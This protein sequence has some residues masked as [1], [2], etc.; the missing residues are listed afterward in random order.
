MEL[1]EEPLV[2]EIVVLDK[3]ISE[4]GELEVLFP[5]E[6][7]GLYRIS[8][9]SVTTIERIGKKSVEIGKVVR[10][11]LSPPG[12]EEVKGQFLAMF[13]E[14]M[15]VVL[16][17]SKVESGISLA[18]KPEEDEIPDA[19]VWC[20]GSSPAL[21]Y[22]GR[23]VLC[24]PNNA[25]GEF[26]IEPP[27]SFFCQSE[28]DGIRILGN[29]VS[30]FIE[31]V[32]AAVEKAFTTLNLDPSSAI[33]K[34]YQMYLNSDPQAEEHLKNAKEENKNSL[35]EGIKTLIKAA[36]AEFSSENQKFLL[37]AASFAKNFIPPGDFNAEEFVDTLKDLR[38]VNQLHVPKVVVETRGSMDA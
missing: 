22:T 19:V 32:P 2:R 4:S 13:N 5:H 3:S 29:L 10:M 14:D 9:E 8:G 34:A 23:L 20:G 21:V 35:A 6:E 12:C 24:G 28:V 37:K 25:K 17:E 38:I 26:N 1:V 33:I 15:D 27:K 7:Q 36:T 30:H 11:V 16:S 18:F 31:K